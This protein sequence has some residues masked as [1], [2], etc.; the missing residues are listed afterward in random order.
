VPSL[1]DF[2]AGKP[3]NER[4]R[5]LMAG[6]E[7]D[8]P[9]IEAEVPPLN[10]AGAPLTNQER[11]GLQR[12]VRSAGWQVLLKLLD[13]SLLHQEDAAKKSSLDRPLVRKDEIAAQW[14][15]LA[16]DAE[17]RNKIVRLAEREIKI[18]EDAKANKKCATGPT[19]TQPATN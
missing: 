2:N 7:D 5:K 17:A 1:E 6:E 4:L 8:E 16:A 10:Y 13:T 11:Q 9:E 12:M 3:L 19:K 15:E 14:A 18:L